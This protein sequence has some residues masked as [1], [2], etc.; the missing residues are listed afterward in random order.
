MPDRWRNGDSV[1]REELLGQ[2]CRRLRQLASKM[3]KGYPAVKSHDE[4]DDVLQSALIRLNRAPEEVPPTTVADYIGLSALQIRRELIDLA[5]RYR[6]Q[7]RCI[8]VGH[9]AGFSS[10]DPPPVADF[11]D[12]TAG[13]ATRAEWTELHSLVEKL[14]QEQLQVFDLHFYHELTLEETAEQLGVSKTKVKVLWRLAR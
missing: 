14:P 3:L 6:R 8:D 13:P 2:S 12:E 10:N 9:D 1:G 4:T 7:R 5:R 11:T